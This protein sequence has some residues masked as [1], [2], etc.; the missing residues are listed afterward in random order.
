MIHNSTIST[1]LLHKIHEACSSGRRIHC[2]CFFLGGRNIKS[3]DGLRLTNHSEIVMFVPFLV[4]TPSNLPKRWVVFFTSEWAQP[5]PSAKGHRTTKCLDPFAPDGAKW[6]E[7]SV[8]SFHLEKS[9][10]TLKCFIKKHLYRPQMRALRQL[11]MHQMH[12]YIQFGH[13]FPINF[14][15][16]CEPKKTRATIMSQRTLAWRW[17]A[18]VKNITV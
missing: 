17:F 4:R 15:Q 18:P 3:V 9:G 8:K 11:Q 7:G 6:M 1:Q 13:K 2:T 12:V 16:K 10:F 14:P 5:V